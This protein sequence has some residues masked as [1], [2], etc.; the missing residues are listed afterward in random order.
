[1]IVR[2]FRSEVVLVSSGQVFPTADLRSHAGMFRWNTFPRLVRRHGASNHGFTLIELLVVVAIIAVLAVF[3]FPALGR[4]QMS[5]QIA[6]SSSQMKQIHSAAM[7]YAADNNNLLPMPAEVPFIWYVKLYPYLMDG[8]PVPSPFFDPHAT[9]ANLKGTV[10]YCPLRAGC[11]YGEPVRSYGW[12]N[13]LK[14]M[15]QNP[16]VRLPLIRVRQPSKTAML[17][18]IRNRSDIQ[19]AG[20]FSYRAGSNALVVFVD[21]HLERLAPANIPTNTFTPFWRPEQP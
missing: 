18:T 9:A 4:M 6:K 12:N 8:K 15:T 3:A 11:D 10:Y 2:P 1:M 5:G 16:R 17:A 7:Q 21:G 20:S 19:N 13:F 14:D